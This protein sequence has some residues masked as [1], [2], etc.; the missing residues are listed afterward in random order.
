MK[1]VPRTLSI[2]TVDHHPTWVNGTT[3][4]IALV[5]HCPAVN[6]FKLTASSFRYRRGYVRTFRHRLPR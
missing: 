4:W 3:K 2:I 5:W 6:R 1:A